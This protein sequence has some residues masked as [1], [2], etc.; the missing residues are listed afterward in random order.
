MSPG[1][2]LLR[3]HS[4]RKVI[5][6]DEPQDDDD[7]PPAGDGDITFQKVIAGTD[8]GLD[9]AVYNIYLDGQIVG[10][11]VTPEGDTSRSTM[12]PRACGPL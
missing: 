9:G 3:L 6:D 10:S 8:K 12:S 5:A 11:D 7:P 1:A 4:G 2:V